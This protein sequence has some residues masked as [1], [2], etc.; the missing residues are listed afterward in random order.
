MPLERG[1]KHTTKINR[2]RSQVRRTS[3]YQILPCF[4]N[5]AM[6]SRPFRKEF[7]A[8]AV[9]HPGKRALRSRRHNARA[10]PS[11]GSGSCRSPTGKA[12]RGPVQTAPRRR[13]DS[14]LAPPV[15][16]SLPASPYRTVADLLE[17]LGGISP[18][19]VRFQ[20][21]PGTATVRDVIAV[22]DAENRLC[23]RV[24]NG[25]SR[26]FDN[27]VVFGNMLCSLSRDRAPGG[28]HALD[29]LVTASRRSIRI[30]MEAS[31]RVETVRASRNG[32]ARSR[33][34]AS[35]EMKAWPR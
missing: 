7:R 9:P 15:A 11:S 28:S 8:A 19:R 6:V 31:T 1:S 20:P 17:H 21:W 22:H 5:D 12:C 23:R 30:G 14:N 33:V 2:R 16:D 24:N 3:L 32:R 26:G 29:D 18:S 34:M 27:R 10:L 25:S 35:G 4:R 13:R